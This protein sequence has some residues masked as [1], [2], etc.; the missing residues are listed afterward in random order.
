MNIALISDT[1]A[2]LEAT[3]RVLR[4]IDNLK[5]DSVICLGDTVGYGPDP[6]EVAR[7]CRENSTIAVLGNHDYAV[8]NA[9][10]HPERKSQI[11]SRFS[12][13]ARNAIIWTINTVSP[14]T[15][16]YLAKLPLEKHWKGLHIVHASPGFPEDWEYIYD[17]QTAEPYMNYVKGWAALIGHTHVPA[18][19][20]KF[21]GGIEHIEP[22]PFRTYNLKK[23][24][25]YILNPGSAGQPR[26][27]DN[28]A[29]MALLDIEERTFRV[30]RLEYDYRTT[31]EKILNAGL[32]EILATRLSSGT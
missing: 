10:I 31:Q 5:V 11:L 2:N 13:T 6:D 29:S 17:S 18:I 27:G 21:L 3:E 16:D 1:H 26:D 22:E 25:I 14:K 32:P 28:R 23:D 8:L 9:F 12:I 4:E 30:L 15:V 7:L 20:R 24:D 19:F